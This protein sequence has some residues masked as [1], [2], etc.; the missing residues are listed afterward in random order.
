MDD[1]RRLRVDKFLIPEDN[2]MKVVD[3]RR[4]RIK[5]SGFNNLTK[6]LTF[7]IYDICYAESAESR[8]QYLEYIDEEYNSARLIKIMGDV[9]DIIGSNILDLSSQDYEPMGASVT[10]LISEYPIP[11]A[12]VAHLDKSHIA[13]HTYPEE[14][15][16]N[17]ISTFR[18]DIDVSTCG[19][20][21]PLR[22]LNY[23]INS[24]E[25]DI[26]LIDYKVRGFTRD[27]RGRKHFI[28]HNINSIQEFIDRKIVN[29]YQIVDFN[30][31]QENLFHTKMLLSD[32]KL[33]DYLF[34]ISAADISE[35]EH[36]RITKLLKR[37]M[38]EIFYAKNI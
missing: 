4:K 3:K 11:K 21:S 2:N 32:F 16:Q 7:N 25:S 31:Y 20:I 5:L 24:F 33:D 38:T 17:G 9:S 30:I 29:S 34:A 10:V 37:E 18:V 28:D 27:I 14:S 1:G 36:L 19:E 23:L 22:A 26:V 6:S 12:K 8:Q 13:A 15:I 35:K